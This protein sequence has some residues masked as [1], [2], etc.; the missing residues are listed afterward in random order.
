MLISREDLK[1]LMHDIDPIEDIIFIVLSL[2]NNII[3]N[4]NIPFENYS[5]FNANTIFL[6]KQIQLPIE[7]P[8]NK[9]GR[10]VLNK[11]MHSPINSANGKII[12]AETL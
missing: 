8:L 4:I 3:H 11:L 1:L 12:V 10:N 5:V 7:S 9:Y 6:S 2:K